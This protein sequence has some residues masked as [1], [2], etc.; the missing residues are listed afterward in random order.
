MFKDS[1]SAT[2]LY[3]PLLGTGLLSECEGFSYWAI[4]FREMRIGGL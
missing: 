1:S 4:G 3:V 2:P